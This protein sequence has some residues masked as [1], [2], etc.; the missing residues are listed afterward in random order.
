MVSWKIHKAADVCTTA[1]FV[2]NNRA[3]FPNT[4]SNIHIYFFVRLGAP[5]H[6]VH[7][8]RRIN[9]QHSHNISKPTANTVDCELYSSTDFILFIYI[10]FSLYLTNNLVLPRPACVHSRNQQ[11]VE[12]RLSTTQ[13][14]PNALAQCRDGKW[15]RGRQGNDGGDEG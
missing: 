12:W 13:T 14:S 9:T 6:T 7:P 11:Q 1:N 3:C 5:T 8:P 15:G 2:R 4:H 10:V